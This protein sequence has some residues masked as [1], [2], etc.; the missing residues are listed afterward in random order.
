MND[1]PC[2]F[3][4]GCHLL[5]DIMPSVYAVCFLSK[6]Y[7][8]RRHAV[9]VIVASEMMDRIVCKRCKFRPMQLRL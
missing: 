9:D 7:V 5:A 2:S 1:E 4:F 8:S 3:A 6:Q